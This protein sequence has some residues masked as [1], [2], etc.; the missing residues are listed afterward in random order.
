MISR[1]TPTRCGPIGVDIGSRSVKLLQL[2]GAR[3][4]VLDAARWD[5]PVEEAASAER[6]DELIVEAIGRAREGRAFRGRKA[7][8]CLNATDLFVQNLRVNKAE[9]DELTKI[10]HFE[11]AGRLP[12]ARELAEMC[13]VEAADV[14]QGDAVRR[15]VILIACQRPRIE[16]LLAIG[17]QAGLQPAAV[18]TEPG[19]MLR[20][21]LKQYRRDDDQQR[22]TLYVNVGSRNTGVLIARGG[23]A[24]FIKYID[25]GGH[26]LDQALSKY[27]KIPMTD[28]TA[29]RRHNGDR[30]ADQRDAE[31]SRSINE[32][33]R[34]LLENLAN[35]LALCVRYHSVTFRGQPLAHVVVGGGEAS[36]SLA[37]WL[38]AKLA[39]PC[40]LG[41][42]L[43]SFGPTALPGR[44]AQWDVATGLALRE[45]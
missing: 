19:A 43:R 44:A 41:N 11:A 24:T 32:A 20:C 10:V 12:F 5:L 21:Y 17:E 42:P 40:E 37:D 6:Q 3:T 9:G 45:E 1:L 15:E 34:P 27:L 25:F 39:M 7:V 14:R 8:L 22:M 31:V 33:I 29:L 18:D 28:A 13:F 38:G 2:N 35:E 16:R 30:R 23:D 26:H 36:E 4:Q